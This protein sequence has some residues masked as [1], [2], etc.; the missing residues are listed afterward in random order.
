MM[1]SKNDIEK[2]LGENQIL[3][4]HICLI[5]T[6]L[7]KAEKKRDEVIAELLE[8]EQIVKQI[9]N[10]LN[11][12]LVENKSLKCQISSNYNLEE[13]SRIVRKTDDI[14]NTLKV[15]GGD[16]ASIYRIE[17]NSRSFNQTWKFPVISRRI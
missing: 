16:S 15:L 17:K 8:Y 7:S 4:K 5:S 12:A 11:S 13:K 2:I 10:D 9:Q 6:D 3:K 14:L 1:E